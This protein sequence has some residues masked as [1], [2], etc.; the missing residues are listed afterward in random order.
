MATKAEQFR[1][2]QERAHPRRSPPAEPRAPKAPR[3]TDGSRRR[4]DH[5]ARKAGYALESGE[6][7]PSRKSTRGSANRQKTDVQFRM[8]KRVSEVRPED[9]TGR[10]S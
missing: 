8:K 9:R 7:R 1:Y 10:R 4:S 3:P 2:E 6:G 5:A